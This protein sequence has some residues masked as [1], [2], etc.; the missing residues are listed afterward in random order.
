MKSISLLSIV[1][2]LVTSSCELFFSMEPESHRQALAFFD[3]YANRNDWSGFLDRYDADMTFEDPILGYKFD[4]R[5]GFKAFYNWPDTSFAK[6]PDYP[7]TLVMEELIT[8]NQRAF[9]SGYFTPFYYQG[10]LYGD[11]EKMSFT[12]ILTFND[13]GE[14]IRQVDWIDYPPEIMKQVFCS[15]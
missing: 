13:E 3:H 14:I 7:K 8:T 5:E 1:L 2:L 11:K 12:I 6:H 10:N 15:Q 9:G 4:N